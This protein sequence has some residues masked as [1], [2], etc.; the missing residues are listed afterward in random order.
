MKKSKGDYCGLG[1]S[2][3]HIR[4]YF[5]FLYKHTHLNFK[6][7]P[8]ENMIQS[9]RKNIKKTKLKTTFKHMSAWNKNHNLYTCHVK[10]ISW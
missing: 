1:M 6:M 2:K 9:K 4:V 3:I 10:Q 7:N 5:V 8:R